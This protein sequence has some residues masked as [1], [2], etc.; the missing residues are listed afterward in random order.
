MTFGLNIDTSGRGT[1]T[2]YVYAPGQTENNPEDKITKSYTVEAK[3]YN[4]ETTLIS[5]GEKIDKI[6]MYYK[7]PVLSADKS[8]ITGYV[9]KKTVLYST[10]G[11]PKG[12]DDY[13]VTDILEAVA[14]TLPDP[15]INYVTITKTTTEK[16]PNERYTKLLRNIVA[17]KTDN[18][19]NTAL[20]NGGKWTIYTVDEEKNEEVS[21]KSEATIATGCTEYKKLSIEN[22]FDITD[23]TFTLGDW[24]TGYTINGKGNV[25]TYPDGAEGKLIE[26][27]DGAINNLGVINGK[28]AEI[29]NNSI[30]IAFETTDGTNYDLYDA[31]G[32]HTEA[33]MSGELAYNRARP[34]FGVT[35]DENGNFGTLD[36]KTAANTVYKAEWTDAESKEKTTFYTNATATDLS[37]NPAKGKNNT[38]AYVLD[39]D[40]NVTAAFTAENVVVK[41]ICKNAVFTDKVTNSSY[42]YIPTKFTAENLSY[43]RDFKASSDLAT[44]CLPFRVSKETLA[45]AGVT[46]VMQFDYVDAATNTYWFRYQTDGILKANE[47]YVLKCNGE[48]FKGG[49]IFSNLSNIEVA[50]TGDIDRY[51]VAP[52]NPGKDAEFRGVLVATNAT[53]LANGGKLY[54]FAEGKFR[55]LTISD[56]TT[57]APFRTY[58][59]ASRE[60]NVPAVTFNIGELDEDGNIVS[61]GGETGVNTAVKEA[62]TFSVKGINGA[63]VITSDKAQRVNVYTIGGSLVKTTNVEAG[64][65]TVPVAA[66]VYVVNGKKVFVK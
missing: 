34:Y 13:T 39:N 52:S 11:I 1:N 56:K 33:P 36:K 41:G 35:I 55:S 30:K 62:D 58:V 48:N 54:G 38:F 32:T 40:L 45:A 12:T 23:A 44:V 63:L 2:L 16:T 61:D 53:E 3:N 49:Q 20:L 64:T 60:S 17:L 8:S 29:N 24:G 21:T 27:N 28:I 9:Y 31:S 15:D 42:V 22:S 50:A 7:F 43:T 46:Q 6:Y 51:A 37:Y 57:F 26:T 14:G 59:R 47:P 4:G 10:K 5:S 19:Y 25:I 65:V 66:G 18:S